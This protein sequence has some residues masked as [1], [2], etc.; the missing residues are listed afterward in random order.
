MTGRSESTLDAPSARETLA[1]GW[2]RHQAGHF[3]VAQQLYLVILR[4]T[5][6][7]AAPGTC[8]AGWNTTAA[9]ATARSNV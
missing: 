5:P 2:K 3:D 9:E 4:T 8:S 6:T 1:R 7:T